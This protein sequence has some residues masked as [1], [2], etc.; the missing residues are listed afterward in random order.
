MVRDIFSNIQ[1]GV[2][3]VASLSLRRDVMGWRQST[4]SGET[5]CKRV[6]VRQFA[7]ANTGILAAGNPALD[8]RNTKNDLQMKKQAE[9]TTLRRMAKVY[10]YLKIWQS[11]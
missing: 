9:D 6:V 5:L 8:T 10:D 1:Q 7:A 2:G 11:R 3:V 4:A